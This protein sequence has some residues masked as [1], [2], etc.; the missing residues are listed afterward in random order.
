MEEELE[1]SYTAQEVKAIE[2]RHEDRE[3]ISYGVEN[4]AKCRAESYRR[5]LVSVLASRDAKTVEDALD[6][7]VRN[8]YGR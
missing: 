8:E 6:V 4:Q 5:A 7:L 1:R 2:K 3:R